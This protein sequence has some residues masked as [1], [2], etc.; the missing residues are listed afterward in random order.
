MSVSPEVAALVRGARRIAVVGLSDD[1]F[2]PSHSVAEYLQ[3][4]GHTIVGVHPAGTDV[5]GVKRYPDLRTADRE[6]G[7]FD[8]V[9]IFRRSDAIPALL[10]DLLA[11][12]PKLVWMQLGVEHAA[13]A[14]ALEA[15]GLTV[16]QDRCL[17]VEHKAL[18][19][20]R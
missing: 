14:A 5:L 2:R 4:S 8:I 20:G 9:D 15:A 3:R 6:E 7:P 13:T 1:P 19:S 12:R 10:P 18:L 17:A 16:V 11:I